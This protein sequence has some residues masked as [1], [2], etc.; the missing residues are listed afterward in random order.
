MIL[1]YLVDGKTL[2]FKVDVVK[3]DDGASL[4]TPNRV[5][6]IL[7]Q[8]MVPLFKDFCQQ[9]SDKCCTHDGWLEFLDN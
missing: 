9:F 1:Y 3:A 2:K 6:V 5:N 4:N 7:Q 8:G